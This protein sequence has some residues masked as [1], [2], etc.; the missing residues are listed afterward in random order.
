M[1]EYIRIRVTKKN[2]PS[3]K[4]NLGVSRGT[5][6]LQMI[7]V[8]VVTIVARRDRIQ[9]TRFVMKFGKHS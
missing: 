9:D 2:L 5:E 3:I 4:R 8:V 6:I 7:I 1:K